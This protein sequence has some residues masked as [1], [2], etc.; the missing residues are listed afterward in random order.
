MSRILNREVKVDSHGFPDSYS[1]TE[2]D[3]QYFNII[4]TEDGS[5]DFFT[6]PPP[7]PAPAPHIP[8]HRAPAFQYHIVRTNT[9]R[10]IVGIS[11]P[12]QAR[13]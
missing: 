1:L 11:L 3:R 4:K 9:S 6:D 12:D 2:T 7:P 13:N 10:P 5:S 8:A